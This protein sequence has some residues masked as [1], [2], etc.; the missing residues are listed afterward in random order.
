MLL[1]PSY[2]D[3]VDSVLGYYAVGYAFESRSEPF[4]IKIF[5]YR[6]EDGFPPH[7]K[8]GSTSLMSKL[9]NLCGSES[10]T[11]NIKFSQENGILDWFR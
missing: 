1:H 2:F 6:R 7:V 5:T 9:V 10:L 11:E 4:F 8:K 3:A